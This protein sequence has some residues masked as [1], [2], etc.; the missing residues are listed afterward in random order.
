MTVP[1]FPINLNPDL[2]RN[3]IVLSFPVNL[4]SNLNRTM[5]VSSFP[6]KL[7]P[8]L[9][10]TPIVLSFPVNLHSELLHLS[11]SYAVCTTAAG[12]VGSVPV[13]NHRLP[14][15]WRHD[16]LPL[17]GSEGSAIVGLMRT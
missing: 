5:T 3:T 4:R 15:G 1:S 7:N 17:T 2:N 9:N 13:S 8:D 11:R 6:L 14:L 10:R 16:P 12:P